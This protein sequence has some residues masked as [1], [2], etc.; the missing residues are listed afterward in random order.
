MFGSVSL[1]F[2]VVAGLAV[3]AA[4]F[5]LDRLMV[6]GVRW[7]I[8]QRTLRVLD[9][10]NRRLPI[11]IQPFRLA[12]RNVLVERLVSDPRVVQAV[13]EHAHEK[14]VP[15]DVAMARAE[16]YAREIVPAFNAYVYFRLGYGVARRLARLLYRVRMGWSDEE[17]LA[18]IERKAAVVFIMNHRSNMD[19]VLVAY[20][21]AGRAAL[22]YAVGEW[23]RV[24]PLQQLIRSM[25]AYLIRRRSDNE[26]YRRVL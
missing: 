22:S 15:L 17:G 7:F 25:G 21:A 24:W 9:E 14:G 8:R 5:V 13:G 1:P 20:L 26:L 19:Y 11:E 18:R 23:A 16:S 6:P 3:L 12:R 4:G 2:W 10:V